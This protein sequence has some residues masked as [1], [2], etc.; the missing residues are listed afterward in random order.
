MMPGGFGDVYECTEDIIILANN[1]KEKVE[2][3]LGETYEVFE[4]ILYTSQIVAGTN[5]NIK[6]HVGEQRFIHMK[7]YVPLPVYNAPNELLECESDK[8]LFD[9]LR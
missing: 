7:I 5:Y 9:P 2:N 4:P 8:T 6:V 3:T 1:M